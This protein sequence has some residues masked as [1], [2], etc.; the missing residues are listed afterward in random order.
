LSKYSLYGVVVV[1]LVALV[2]VVVR[3]MPAK[4]GPLIPARMASNRHNPD[5]LKFYHLKNV[6]T[7]NNPL[8]AWKMTKNGGVGS[9]Y[10]F[11]DPHGQ[12]IDSIKDPRGVLEK[13]VDVKHNQPIVTGKD[14]VPNAQANL[15]PAAGNVLEIQFNEAGSKKFAEFTR[16]NVDEYLAV[17]FEDKLITAPNIKIAITGGKAQIS[18]FPSPQEAKRAAEMLN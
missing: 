9:G 14:L 5:A 13:V 12:L 10:I 2:A 15:D 17:F 16:R 7:S 6:Q 3:N 1:I 18:G 8:A 11:M 4:T